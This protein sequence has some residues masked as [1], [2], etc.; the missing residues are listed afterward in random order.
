MRL[1]RYGRTVELEGRTLE[2]SA[3]EFKLLDALMTKGEGVTARREFLLLVV[4][5]IDGPSLTNVLDVYIRYL[6]VKIGAHRIET[7]RGTGYRLAVPP[8]LVRL[9]D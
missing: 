2:L 1:D 6:R 8:G 5:K 4:W 9:N 7:V 3:I